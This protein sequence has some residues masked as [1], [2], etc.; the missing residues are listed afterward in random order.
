MK[1]TLPVRPENQEG[2]EGLPLQERRLFKAGVLTS[3]ELVVAF[4]VSLYGFAN[5]AVSVAIERS[6]AESL[7]SRVIRPALAPSV[8][9]VAIKRVQ[10][11]RRPC[12][13]DRVV[14][15]EDSEKRGRSA[16]YSDIS[17]IIL[18]FLPSVRLL[19]A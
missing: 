12:E 2:S 3:N 9:F 14:M 19:F 8:F 6:F 5:V 4:A 10:R 16:P 15:L 1:T 13:G 11:S 17:P 18:R 7:R